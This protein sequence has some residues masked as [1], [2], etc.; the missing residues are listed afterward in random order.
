MRHLP[1]VDDL[2][3]SEL[4]EVLDLA[5]DEHP[6][7]VLA[8]KGAALVFEKPSARTL[9]Q[10]HCVIGARAHDHRVLER[11]AAVSEVPVVNLPSDRSH[12]LQAMADLI[13]L[14]DGHCGQEVAAEVIDGPASL[15]WAQAA[16]RL[17]AI[18]DFLLWLFR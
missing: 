2:S 16:N 12:P 10:Y 9:S 15:V 18:R 14:Q 17:R 7:H 1:D 5:L 4:A 6:P 13:T 8:G 11:M 3:A